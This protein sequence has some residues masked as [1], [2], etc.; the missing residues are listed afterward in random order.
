MVAAA[1]CSAPRKRAQRKEPCERAREKKKMEEI[2]GWVADDR[3][4]GGLAEAEKGRGRGRGRGREGL[5]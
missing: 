2:S 1:T 3:S 5:D 4:V